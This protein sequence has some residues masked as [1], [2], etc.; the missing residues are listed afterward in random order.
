MSHFVIVL[1]K[2]FFIDNTFDIFNIFYSLE[3]PEGE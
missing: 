3:E 1:K 2:F